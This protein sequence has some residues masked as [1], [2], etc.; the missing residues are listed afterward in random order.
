[1]LTGRD[2]GRVR[3][4]VL[5][6]L[7]DG[8]IDILIGTHAI[9]QDSVA[10]KNL[11]LVVIDEQHRFG[12]GQR[13]MLAQ[14]GRRAPHCLAMTATPIPRTLTL[15][16]YGEMDVSKLDEMPPGRQPIDTRVVAVERLTDVVGAIGRHL[17]S[18]QQAYWVCPMVR[19]LE[20]E[21]I[22]AAE[23]RHAELRARFGDTVVLVHGQLRPEAKDAEIGRAH[24]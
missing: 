14:K 22:A 24:V 18:G 6:G 15:A 7:A 9:F 16:Q 10:Y 3:E 2:K 21:D 8:S 17:E 20:N 11:A 12:V 1:M 23:A 4:S 19:E 5:M 13:L